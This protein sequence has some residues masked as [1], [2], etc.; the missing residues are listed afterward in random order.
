MPAK[1]V[2][3][4][5]ATLSTKA[6][7]VAG[8]GVFLGNGLMEYGSVFG[9]GALPRPGLTADYLHRSIASM[10]AAA[11]GQP[12]AAAAADPAAVTPTPAA[13]AVKADLRAN[14]YDAAGGTC[15]S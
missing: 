13:S 9:D 1:V 4:S 12:G 2:D 11:M 10:E 3:G 5:G 14:R 6:D 7:I 8:Q 15:S